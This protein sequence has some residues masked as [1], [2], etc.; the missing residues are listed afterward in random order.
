M[1]AISLQEMTLDIGQAC[2]YLNKFTKGWRRIRFLNVFSKIYNIIYF[3]KY[4][5]NR[6]I[7]I[8]IIYY[9]LLIILN[10][11]INDKHK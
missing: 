9:Y 7:I 11:L 5:F 1:F 3:Y 4:I 10:F 8:I 6:F 2:L